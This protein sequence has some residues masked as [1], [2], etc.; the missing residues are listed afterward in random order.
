MRRKVVRGI[1]GVVAVSM[2][3]M[4][5]VYG[6]WSDRLHI[7]TQIGTGDFAAEYGDHRD[8]YVAIVDK[9][10]NYREEVAA[11]CQLSP[12]GQTLTIVFH[13]SVCMPTLLDEEQML[14][15]R[16][17]VAFKEDSALKTALLVE[18]DFKKPSPER[19]EALPQSASFTVEQERYALPLDYS[20]WSVPLAFEVYRTVIE[21]NEAYFS[22]VYLRPAP[23]EAAQASA[24]S[25]AIG[26]SELPTALQ[27]RVLSSGDSSG[28]GRLN[29]E[30]QVTYRMDVPVYLEQIH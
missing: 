9:L 13:E 22:I 24:N 29:G 20:A 16:T 3:L 6:E 4:G 17:P 7:S 26:I 27:E 18:P 28:T 1:L 8:V 12:D 5:T 11:D 2:L 25:Q 10:G 19:L 23:Q 21:E 30:I 15:I 14:A